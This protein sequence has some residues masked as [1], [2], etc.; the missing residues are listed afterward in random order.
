MK[1]AKQ[2]AYKE[3]ENNFVWHI[4]K[5]SSVMLTCG[6]SASAALRP[7]MTWK[8]KG[9]YTVSAP[10]NKTR[11]FA[12]G[13]LLIM[14]FGKSADMWVCGWVWVGECVCGCGWGSVCMVGFGCV[15][16]CVC[17]GVSMCVMKNSTNA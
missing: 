14:D 3:K 16:G 12:N 10:S 13:T 17:V 15:C 6:G 4:Y 8:H 1:T 5:G 11:I 9:T 7:S 2:P